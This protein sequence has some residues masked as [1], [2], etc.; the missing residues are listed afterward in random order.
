[1]SSYFWA[2]NWRVLV[3]LT[4]P[5]QFLVHI[6]QTDAR[7]DIVAWS[8]S[9]CVL[10]VELM[11]AWEGNWEEVHKQKKILYESLWSNCME[12][13]W[14]CHVLPIKVNA[15]DSL[16]GQLFPFFWRWA[17]LAGTWRV[18][19]TISRPQPNRHQI[20]SGQDP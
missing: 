1:M 18:L 6:I 7:P 8:D 4:T 17:S 15:V 16:D 12:K 10:L 14:T 13:G 11:D 3:N 19:H 20:R 2:R 5:L 9:N